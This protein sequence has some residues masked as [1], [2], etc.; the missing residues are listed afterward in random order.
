MIE[1]VTTSEVER[2]DQL[3]RRETGTNNMTE[4][5]DQGIKERCGILNRKP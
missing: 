2:V 5:M 1:S 3:C 4:V